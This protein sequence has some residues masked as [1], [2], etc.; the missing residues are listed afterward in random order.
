LQDQ[1]KKDLHVSLVNKDHLTAT[2]A[3]NILANNKNAFPLRK[4]IFHLKSA[5]LF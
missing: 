1:K 5:P 4:G 2:T 3:G